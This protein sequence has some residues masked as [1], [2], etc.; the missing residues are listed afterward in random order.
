MNVAAPLKFGMGAS[1]R[2]V[3]DGSL[4]RGQGRYTADFMPTAALTG[5]VLRSAAAHA[6]ISLG[7]LEE[8]RAAPGV[9]LVWTAE[10]VRDLG[11]MPC[12]AK[13]AA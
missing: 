9:H 6:R 3:E 2:R 13:P 4:I 1:P 5:Y 11:P 7:N 12:M 10:D 8:A